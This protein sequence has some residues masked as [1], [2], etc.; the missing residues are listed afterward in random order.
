MLCLEEAMTTSMPASSRSASSR[1]LSKASV[2]FRPSR[3]A[4]RVPPRLPAPSSFSSSR[5]LV[6]WLAG[7]ARPRLSVRLA[8]RPA[9]E[10]AT[11][12]RAQESGSIDVRLVAGRSVRPSYQRATLREVAALDAEG[13]QAEGRDAERDVAHREGICRR[14][15]APVASCASRAA[16]RSRGDASGRWRSRSGRAFPAACGPAP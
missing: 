5:L 11:I 2:G 14:R 7:R 4:A 6:Y 9:V 1:S 13:E 3:R 10:I 16:S 12:S 15:K 8:R